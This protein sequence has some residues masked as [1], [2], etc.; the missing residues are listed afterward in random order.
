MI[1][2]LRKCL[3]FLSPRMRWRW[4][5]LI[6][7]AVVAALLEASGAAVAFTLIKII[8]NPSQVFALPVVSTITKVLPWRDGKAMILPFSI[9]AATFYLLKNGLLFAVAYTQNKVVSDSMA[10]LSRRM[11]KGYLTIPYAFHFRRNSAELIR[12]TTDSV[13]VAC[14]LV[15]ASAVHVV[16][17]ILVMIGIASVLI[18]TTPL[19]AFVAIVILFGTLV[20]LLRLTK[21]TVTRWGAQMQEL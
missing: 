8:S 15:M 1:A 3:T 10:A 2:T 18:A 21:R 5:G 20:T 13:D 14:R 9:G 6:P 4:A 16:T 19:M 17:E 11:L 7:L 12:N